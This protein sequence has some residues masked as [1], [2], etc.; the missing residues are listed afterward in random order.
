ML[1]NDLIKPE[2]RKKI[3]LAAAA[4]LLLAGGWRLYSNITSEPQAAVSVT[5]VRTLTVGATSAT[6]Q[7]VYA[8]EVRGRY[9]SQLAFQVSGRINARLVNVGDTVSAGQTLMTLDPKDVNQSLESAEAQLAAAAANQKLAADNAA[10]YSK[11]FADGAVSEAVRDQ[12]VTQLEAANASLRQAQASVNA[13]SNQLAYTQLTSD[14]DGVVASLTAEVGQVAAAGSPVATVIRNGEREIQISVPEN[15]QLELGQ[16]A[17]VSFWSLPDVQVQGSI[18]EIAP[19]A[20]SVTR[21]YKVKISV[22]QLPAAAKLGMT[23]SVTLT[24]A[25]T[26][27]QSQQELLIPATALYQVNDKTQVWLVRDNKAV[28]QSVTVGG[29]SGN[30][31]RIT[32]GLQAGDVLITAGLSKLVEAQPVQPLEGGE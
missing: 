30:S 15:V 7:K 2:Y 8:G 10:R 21:T 16:Q 3:A 31:V 32:S 22:P 28:L 17:R 12:Y 5:R 4:V 6:G 27:A 9:E 25:D 24:P 18:R 13:N 26:P 23:A 20:D 1:P 14:A 19:M 29:Y 11:L